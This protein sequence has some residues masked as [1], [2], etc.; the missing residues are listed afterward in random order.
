MRSKK[1]MKD[2]LMH[3]LKKSF[4]FTMLACMMLLISACGTGNGGGSTT[5]SSTPVASLTPA[6][7][8][9]R[10]ATTMGQL[11]SVSYT[12]NSADGVTL[13]SLSASSSKSQTISTTIKASGVTVSPDDT[14][15]QLSVAILGQTL[16]FSEVV[17]DQK[18]YVQNQ[19]GQWYVVNKSASQLSSIAN[20]D[21]TGYN[22][23]LAL[24]DIKVTDDG[25]T[26]L[27]GASMRHL[28][29]TFGNG[30]L[31]DLLNT[32][33]TLNSLPA[34]QKQQMSKLLK[35]MTMK[36]TVLD[37]WIDN[38]TAYLSRLQLQFDL[39]MNMDISKLITPTPGTAAST[40]SMDI[41][42]NTTI[43]YSKFNVPVTITA[44]S[45]ATPTSDI[46]KVFS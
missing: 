29:I 11:K 21:V 9:Q 13:P 10:T 32:T 20:T 15:L 14:K 26:T 41:N 8:L 34:S 40:L 31:S 1:F 36:N 16:S 19:K 17:K 2:V 27:N 28:T 42:Q 18:V 22:K 39:N 6:Q 5:G 4:L 24:K 35:D 30:A 12:M 3:M 46:T 25:K 23:L 37:V 45:N 7:L 38:T 43:D 33:G 44:P